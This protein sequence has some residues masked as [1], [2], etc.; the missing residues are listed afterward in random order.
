MTIGSLAV[1]YIISANITVGGVLKGSWAWQYGATFTDASGYGNTATPSFRT[2]SSAASVN[3]TLASFLPVNQAVSSI[4][5]N[6]TWG[7]MV[8]EVPTQPGTT[9][10]ENATPGIF[11]QPIIHAI[12]PESGLPESF[13]WYSFA[14]AII[15]MAGL[16]VFYFF[17]GKGQS[18]L[19]IKV[20]VMMAFIIFFSLPGPNIFGMYLA[21]YFGM[22]S[23]GVLVLSRSYGW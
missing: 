21:I 3:A 9:Y 5:A 14:F 2:T 15:T 7:Q 10:T 19:L 18:A 20:I 16:G 4:S 11:F 1:P 17:A 6:S 22:F 23:F 8:T 13:F 12:W